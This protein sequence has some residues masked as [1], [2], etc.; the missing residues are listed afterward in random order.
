VF[1]DPFTALSIFK[2]F[3]GARMLGI[4]AASART[5]Y[6]T[7]DPVPFTTGKVAAGEIILIDDRLPP[8]SKGTRAHYDIITWYLGQTE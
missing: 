7:R 1:L 2:P 3:S 4:N 5:W 8:E 6:T